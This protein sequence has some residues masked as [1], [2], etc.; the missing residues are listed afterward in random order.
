[1]DINYTNRD[2]KQATA[3][4]FP[5]KITTD[6]LLYCNSYYIRTQCC[7]VVKIN[8]MSIFLEFLRRYL[9]SLKHEMLFKKNR[10]RQ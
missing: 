4:R 1:M 2:I 5:P 10:C 7:N 6:L 9:L 3:P 8:R